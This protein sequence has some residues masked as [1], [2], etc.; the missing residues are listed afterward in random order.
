MKIVKTSV[1]LAI[2]LVNVVM[3]MSRSHHKRSHTSTHS[4]RSH[5]RATTGYDPNLAKTATGKILD[6]IIKE[7][8][9]GV[10][11]AEC[12]KSLIEG[13][14]ATPYLQQIYGHMS[15]LVNN[16]GYKVQPDWFQGLLS[17]SIKLKD[18][19]DCGSQLKGAMLA[20]SDFNTADNQ[21]KFRSVIQ[22]EF[23]ATSAAAAKNTPF[24]HGAVSSF[25]NSDLINRSKLFQGLNGKKTK[26]FKRRI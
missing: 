7:S 16:E 23:G 13:N 9:A 8:A 24:L 5:S 26:K 6:S 14:G 17:Q 1:L 3:I 2:L 11:Y 18:G 19:T 10:N 25:R 22:G 4:R 15:T 20:D 21:T 12:K